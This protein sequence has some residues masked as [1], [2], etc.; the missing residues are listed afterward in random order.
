MTNEYIAI[1]APT[2]KLGLLAISK[3]V[4]ENI[5]ATAIGELEDIKLADKTSLKAPISCHIDS[6]G[7]SLTLNIRIKYH[8]NISASCLLA[9][10][11]VN[12]ALQQMVSLTCKE[13]DIRVVGFIF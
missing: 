11:R 5:A 7:I 4:I 10:N 8:A 13:I 12:Q 2:N 6:D 1:P 3:S 9:Q